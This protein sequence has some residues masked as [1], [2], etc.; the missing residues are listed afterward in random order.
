MDS[1]TPVRRPCRPGRA[2]LGRRHGIGGGRAG[3]CSERP[4]T[5]RGCIRLRAAPIG[6]PASAVPCSGFRKRPH[7]HRGSQIPANTLF[8]LQPAQQDHCACPAPRRH[9]RAVR[10]GGRVPSVGVWRAA[11]GFRPRGAVAVKEGARP[12]D[13]EGPAPQPASGGVLLALRS[14]QAAAALVALPASV[15][16]GG[17]RPLR[18]ALCFPTCPSKSQ[19]MVRRDVP[20]FVSRSCLLDDY[21]CSQGTLRVLALTQRMLPSQA[22]KAS[23]VRVRGH[24]R[25]AVLDRYC[26]VLRVG[27]QTSQ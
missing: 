19:G 6:R 25:A 23:E 22:G 15:L 7:S 24:H 1:P 20:P 8:V 2:R 21:R 10:A 26:W 18:P 14:D 3:S 11:A 16:R 9:R 5:H 4:R 12:D 27:H 13:E 17:R